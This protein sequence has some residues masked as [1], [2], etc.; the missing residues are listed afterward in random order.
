MKKITVLRKEIVTDVR[1]YEAEISTEKFQELLEE[2]FDF[3]NASDELWDEL[4]EAD[5]D[6][7]N[8]KALSPDIDYSIKK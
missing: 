3:E 7:V 5:W 6:F 1:W 4:D 8:D 2:G